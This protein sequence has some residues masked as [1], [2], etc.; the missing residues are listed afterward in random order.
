MV[1]VATGKRGSGDIDSPILRGSGDGLT[2]VAIAADEKMFVWG[3]RRC[4]IRSM[5]PTWR[6]FQKWEKFFLKDMLF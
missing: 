1:A 2:E 6:S 5:F 3:K 4:H